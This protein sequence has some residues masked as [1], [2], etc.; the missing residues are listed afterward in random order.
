MVRWFTAMLVV[1][2]FG[3]IL[4]QGE[5]MGNCVTIESK[6][7]Q[8]MKM[9]FDQ[10]MFQEGVRLNKVVKNLDLWRQIVHTN[11]HARMDNAELDA[12][13]GLAKAR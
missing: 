10:R 1:K 11:K 4:E 5:I 13:S 6:P 2:A 7:S 8:D 3:G 12:Q 9:C